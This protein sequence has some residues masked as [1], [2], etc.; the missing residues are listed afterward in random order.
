MISHNSSNNDSNNDRH[1]L[2]EVRCEC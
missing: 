2:T 1:T